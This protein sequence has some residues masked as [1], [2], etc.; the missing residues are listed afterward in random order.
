MGFAALQAPRGTPNRPPASPCQVSLPTE[1][2][3]W[4][5]LSCLPTLGSSLPRLPEA[6]KNNCSLFVS[7]ISQ[8]HPPSLL[9]N[10][11]FSF[12]HFRFPKPFIHPPRFHHG[13]SRRSR[14]LVLRD[15][16]RLARAGR[17]LPHHRLYMFVPGHRLTR[18]RL[19]IILRL[20]TGSWRQRFSHTSPT[21]TKPAKLLAHR[22]PHNQPRRMNPNTRDR[23]R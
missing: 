4:I 17:S 19:P 5:Y 1:T 18:S 11:S 6:S 13:E 16:R 20:V 2:S 23:E 3:A 21:K 12:S 9:P 22:L 7:S 8:R 10:V 14:D 15:G